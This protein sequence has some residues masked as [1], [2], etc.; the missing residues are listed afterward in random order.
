MKL[1]YIVLNGN[2]FFPVLILDLYSVI[3]LKL[4][5][6]HFIGCH[7]VCLG[8]MSRDQF[9]IAIEF[10]GGFQRP[11]F[12]LMKDILNVHYFSAFK[13]KLNAHPQKLLHERSEEHTSELQSLM[14]ISYAVF[15]LKKKKNTL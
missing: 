8:R 10:I 6:Q 11:L 15:C 7:N 13:I 9:L 5:Q 1:L 12:H 14:R 2:K 3:A 4:G